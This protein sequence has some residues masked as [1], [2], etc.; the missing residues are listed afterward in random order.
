M[1]KILGRVLELNLAFILALSLVD[2][3][4]PGEAR[5][6]WQAEWEKTVAAAHREGEVTLY[7]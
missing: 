3:V 4:M 7:G 2:P 5:T 6:G 1:T